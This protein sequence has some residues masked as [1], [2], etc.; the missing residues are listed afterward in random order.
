[1]NIDLWYFRYFHSNHTLGGKVFKQSAVKKSKPSR[2]FHKRAIKRIAQSTKSAPILP[3][4]TET[5]PLGV[6]DANTVL[7]LQG[8]KAA[9][10]EEILSVETEDDKIRRQTT[11]FN[12]KLRKDPHNIHLWT[13]FIEFQ[14]TARFVSDK[15]E[16]QIKEKPRKSLHERALLERKISILDKAIENNPK[17][18]FLINFRLQIAA[19]YWDLSALQLEWRNTLFAHP[20]SIFLWKKYLSFMENFFEG[21]SVQTV[22]K[23]Y[24]NC[25]KKLIQIQNPSFTSHAKPSNLVEHMIGTVLF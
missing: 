21:F 5:N 6:Y 16:L 4:L 9:A 7:F 17:N 12:E 14:D 15:K 20:M 23:A 13:E 11:L 3:Q 2:Y 10:P 19:E 8:Q 18:E 24:S 22:L 25:I 1:M